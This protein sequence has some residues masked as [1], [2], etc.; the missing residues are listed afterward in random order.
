MSFK[1]PP[2]VTV[3]QEQ[4]QGKFA[5]VLRH[6]KLGELGRLVLSEYMG[7]THFSH[8]VVG[9]ENDP[10][11]QTRREILEPITK[12]MVSEVEKKI[13]KRGSDIQPPQNYSH[14]IPPK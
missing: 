8:E 14:G 9:D 11:T 12:A 1:L 13:G 2:E 6:E 3:K 5:Y 7:Q 10:L 4:Y